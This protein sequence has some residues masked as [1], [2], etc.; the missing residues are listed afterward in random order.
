[1]DKTVAVKSFDNYLTSKPFRQIGECVLV[2]WVGDS[3]GKSQKP[4]Y[5]KLENYPKT[6][7][8]SPTSIL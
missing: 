5:S 3:S 2:W 1:M 7:D 6:Q 8:K 4:L